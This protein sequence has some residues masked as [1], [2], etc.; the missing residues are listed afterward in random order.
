MNWHSTTLR[1]LIEHCPQ[2]LRWHLDDKPFNRDVFAAGI[3]AHAML[4]AFTKERPADDKA[5]A[6]LRSKVCELLISGGYS[7]MGQA[8]P[9][10]AG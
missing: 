4:E 6:A 5:L 1:Y 8:A 7:F 9:A 10:P 2:A 3:A